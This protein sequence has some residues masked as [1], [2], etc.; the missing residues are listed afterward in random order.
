M[1]LMTATGTL[2]LDPIA[3]D[4]HGV[5]A[6]LV[7]RDSSDPPREVELPLFSRDDDVVIPLMMLRAGDVLTVEGW[8]NLAP[9]S[10][11]EMHGILFGL[12]VFRLQATPATAVT[13]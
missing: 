2:A 10:T 13:P 12:T 6:T 4:E 5:L 3:D 8:V 1:M 7:T 11:V 9:D